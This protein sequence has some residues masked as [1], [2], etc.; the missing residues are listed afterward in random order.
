M[1]FSIVTFVSLPSLPPHPLR[2]Q[3]L[4]AERAINEK[5]STT[6]KHF[7]NRKPTN[8]LLATTRM[9]IFATVL[10]VGVA[11]SKV[12]AFLGQ[13]SSQ[14]SPAFTRLSLSS[15]DSYKDALTTPETGSASSTEGDTRV[16]RTSNDSGT[17]WALPALQPAIGSGRCSSQV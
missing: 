2:S 14:S 1:T 7:S 16:V 12:S 15:S 8:S 13:S 17:A 10:A 3:T 4:N 9:K 6:Q 11:Q 5:T